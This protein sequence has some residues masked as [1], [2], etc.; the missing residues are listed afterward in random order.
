MSARL[1]KAVAYMVV[2]TKAQQLQKCNALPAAH[3]L[4]HTS[5]PLTASFGILSVAAA[6]VGQN[7]V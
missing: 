2:L 3:C 5:L 7:H 6:S 4:Q 1:Q